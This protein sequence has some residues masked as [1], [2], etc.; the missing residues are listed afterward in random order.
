M[1]SLWLV[2]RLQ[3]VCSGGF[4][5]EAAEAS[6]GQ[7]A[8]PSLPDVAEVTTCSPEP[9]SFPSRSHFPDSLAAGC[10]LVAAF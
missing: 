10:D 8:Q 5:P 4:R 7:E 2:S 6:E 3:Q 9:V 1:H